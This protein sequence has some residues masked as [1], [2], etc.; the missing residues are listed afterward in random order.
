MRPTIFVVACSLLFAVQ[1]ARAQQQNILDVGTASQLLLDPSLVY[2]SHGVAFTPHPAK[3]HGGNPLVKADRTWEGWYVSAFAGTVL[4]DAESGQFK[5]WY[6]CPSDEVFFA[7]PAS[8]MP[9]A[10][11][12]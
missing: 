7:G 4:R 2:E 6:S 12:G 5:M 10:A 11:T 1:L 8:V 9:P 3:K